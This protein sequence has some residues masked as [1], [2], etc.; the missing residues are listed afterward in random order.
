MNKKL[1]EFLILERDADNDGIQDKYM[2]DLS[3]KE[4][5]KRRKEIRKNKEKDLNDPSAYSD[6]SWETDD[7]QKTKKSKHTKKYEEIY[8]E[9][10]L[11]KALLILEKENYEK[12]LK[13]KSEESGI[14]YNILKK[15][16]DRGLAA[17]KSGHRP[18]ATQHQWAMARVNSFI[19]GGKTRT[20][21]DK[22]L[23]KE[24]KSN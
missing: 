1:S 10:F 2:S 4:K 17:Y 14:S 12:G 19:T 11:S 16:Y 7:G 8:G 18:G 20:T 3:K 5:E 22:D 9:G 21:A 24:H 15:V 6:D 13:N 23:W